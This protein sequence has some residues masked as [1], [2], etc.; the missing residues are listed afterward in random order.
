MSWLVWLV[1]PKEFL[2]AY[3][4]HLN[5]QLVNIPEKLTQIIGGELSFD[6]STLL[7]PLDHVF[8]HDTV[9]FVQVVNHLDNLLILWLVK[10]H[11]WSITRE[12]LG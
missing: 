3:W 7:S 11:Q 1:M 2:K 12:I 9:T 10:V 5:K 8:E 6:I 4:G